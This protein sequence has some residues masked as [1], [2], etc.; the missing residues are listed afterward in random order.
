MLRRWQAVRIVAVYGSHFPGY[1][2][3]N[4]KLNKL[5]KMLGELRNWE[6]LLELAQSLD[7]PLIIKSTFKKRRDALKIQ[8]KH[9]LAGKSLAKAHLKFDRVIKARKLDLDLC[10]DGF[11]AGSVSS[12]EHLEPFLEKLEQESRKLERTAQSAADFHKLRLKIKTW[13][14]FLTEF[15]AV[16]SLPLVKAQQV[17][18]KLHDFDELREVLKESKHLHV[19][20]NATLERIATMRREVLAEFSGL[21]R[22]LPYG[23][24]PMVVSQAIETKTV[25]SAR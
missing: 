18:G 8:A 7:M 1:E 24:R 20:D 15:F 2:A 13:R 25:K 3:L 21:R 17:L 19:L 4:T 6:I 14:Y 12:Y 11:D 16:T 22:N 5:R 23:L 10:K 9:F